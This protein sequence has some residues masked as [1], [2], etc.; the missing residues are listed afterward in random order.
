M[1]TIKVRNYQRMAHYPLESDTFFTGTPDRLRFTSRWKRKWREAIVKPN[2]RY[3]DIIIETP[4]QGENYFGMNRGL[5]YLKALL[6]DG[7]GT[8]W[9]PSSHDVWAFRNEPLK[10]NCGG[11]LVTSVVMYDIFDTFYD[12]NFHGPL[13]KLFVQF[14]REYMMYI[15]TSMVVMSGSKEGSPGVLSL[16][17][18]LGVEPACIEFNW[19]SDNKLY[20]YVMSV[21]ELNNLRKR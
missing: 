6:K 16:A 19:N 8:G 17:E 1:H 21:A 20:G 10:T 5:C 9:G 15:R 13:W 11:T 7:K 2:S 18:N 12:F 4:G 14:F 3:S